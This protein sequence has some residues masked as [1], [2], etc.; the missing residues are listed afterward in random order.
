[1][2]L[3]LGSCGPQASGAVVLR[4]GSCG[5][6]ARELWLAGSS[7]GSGVGNLGLVALRYVDSPGPGVERMPPA[8]AGGFL[9][10]VPPAKSEA[11]FLVAFTGAKN[12]CRSSHCQQ[13]CKTQIMLTKKAEQPIAVFCSCFFSPI[14]KC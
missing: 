13:D 4:P 7:V 8:L 9:S 11:S 1:M 6:Q 3:R 14:R 2:A 10:A 5:P 12:R